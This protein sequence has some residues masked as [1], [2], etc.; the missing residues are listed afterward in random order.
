MR[1]VILHYHLFKNAG[2]SLDASFKDWLGDKKWATKEFPGALNP[3][4]QQ[5]RQWIIDNP[6]VVCF[7]SH[8]AHLPPPEIEGVRVIPILFIRHPLDRILSAYAFEKKQGA[9]TLGSVIARNTTL[10][11]YLEIFLSQKNW[12]QVSN[13]HCQRLA[14][15]FELPDK[16]LVE[17]A[18]MAVDALPFIGVVEDYAGS[19]T[20]LQRY[21]ENNGFKDVPL[22]TKYVNTNSKRSQT[23]T[24]RLEEIRNSVEPKVYSKLIENN[25]GDLSIYEKV[26]SNDVE[27]PGKKK[28]LI[29]YW[30]GLASPGIESLMEEWEAMNDDY[31][32]VRFNEKS[33]FEFVLKFYGEIKAK[34]FSDINFQAMKS[35]VFRLAAI[36]I[37]GGVYIDAATKC[38]QSISAWN[39]DHNVPTFIKKRNGRIANAL[40]CSPA[41]NQLIKLM[42]EQAW[43]AIL[44]KNDGNIWLQTGPGMLKKII[45]TAQFPYQLIDQE[46]EDNHF[47]FLHDFEHKKSAHWSKQ[48]LFRPLYNISNTDLTCQK[49]ERFKDVFSDIELVLH[50][51]HHKTGTTSI[52]NALLEMQDS[53]I[54]YPQTGL[55]NVGHHLWSDILANGNQVKIVALIEALASEISGKNISRIILSSEYFSSKNE[56]EFD[57][58]RM[59]NIWR[60]LSAFSNCFKKSNVIFYA[61][62]QASAIDSRIK[63]AIK[64]RI[65]LQH[66]NWKSIAGNPC[67][68][69]ASFLEA[70]LY[71]FPNANVEPRSFD[72]AMKN[73]GVVQDFSSR[74]AL[75]LKSKRANVSNNNIKLYYNLLEINKLAISIEHKME[76]KQALFAENI[77]G[78]VISRKK[79]IIN[80]FK[81]NR[82]IN[83]P[84]TSFLSD[85]DK[86]EIKQM[87]AEENNIFKSKVNK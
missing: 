21:L 49:I 20:R 19:I 8:S 67:F 54:I 81:K 65:C 31:Q 83:K 23:L 42:L 82:L 36:N 52:Q 50:I 78:E 60:F 18:V 30:T 7:S 66:I 74:L 28:H 33:A 37:L 47:K 56:V 25:Q 14:A 9:D 75:N 51:G 17:R 86:E 39:I 6:D 40:I 2:S 87:F 24:M 76:K 43:I 15:Y 22:K 41:D 48:Q 84:L 4:R 11:G 29:Q 62:E 61:R 63:Q 57:K 69:Y 71:Y 5:V 72:I 32:Y 58:Q 53:D 68:S 46:N 44:E 38:N 13:F 55:I 34:A 59:V 79:L 27:L 35:D 73:G 70:M 77:K 10:S 45:D 64:S 3:N 1:T 12:H 80:L 16:T 85:N 26:T